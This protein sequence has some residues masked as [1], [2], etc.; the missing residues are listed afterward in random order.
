MDTPQHPFS[1]R[2][3]AQ[4]PSRP[5]FSPAQPSSTQPFGPTA[6]PL[7]FD[8]QLDLTK[9][10]SALRRRWQILL[11]SLLIACGYAFVQYSLTP[12][13]YQAT[14][15]VQIERKRLSLLALGQ[16]GWLEDWWNMEYYPT[17]Y[18][19]LRSRGM[20][21]KVVLHLGLHQNPSFAPQNK[22][23]TSGDEDGDSEHISSSTELAHLATSVMGRLEVNPIQE[24]QLVELTY[25]STDP[26][27]AAQIANTYAEVFIAWGNQDRSETVTKASDVLTERVESLRQEIEQGQIRL[28]AYI[29]G[30]DFALDPAGEALVEQLKTLRERHSAAYASRFEKEAFYRQISNLSRDTFVN[31]H[32]NPRTQALKSEL[33][34]LESQYSSKL[35]TY[36]PEWPEMVKLREAIE[37]KKEEVNRLSDEIYLEAR[38]QASAEY[39]L[40]KREEEALQTEINKLTTDARLQN[41][42][43][44]EY[45]NQLTYIDTRK[46]L[47]TDLVKRQS[48]IA[49]QLQSTQESNVR[50]VDRAI[51][52]GG[53]FRPSLKK[54]LGAAVVIGLA[55]GVGLIFLL[56]YLD[57]TIKTPDELESILGIPTLTVIP[58]LNDPGSARTGA[59]KYGYSYSY[60]YGSPTP[61]GE[62][63]SEERRIELLPHFNPRLAVSEAYR[64][65]RTALLLSSAD[66]LKVVALTSAEPGEGKTATTA[67]LAVVMAQLGRRVLIIDAD[68]RRPRMHKVF[69]VSNRHGLVHFLTN[70]SNLDS[71]F[72]PTEA[73]DLWICP[74]GPIPPNPSELLASDRMREFLHLVRAR[75]DFVLIDTPPTLPVADAVIL[76]PLADGIVVCARAGV[77]TRD[78]AKVC[79]ERLRYADLRIF[80]AVLNRYRS[81][82]HSYGKRYHYYGGYGEPGETGSEATSAA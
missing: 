69:N 46:E 78:D 9:Y 56:E 53:P 31:T 19:L 7:D 25:R 38:D 55:L 4:P 48:E 58:D 36:K 23:T 70:Q 2:E 81:S 35:S 49:T 6:S 43:A 30:S 3:E 75:F 65:L 42:S 40:A 44:L 21:E 13:E 54:S 63:K 73:P 28:N 67:N 47:L 12:K 72:L 61:P 24:T 76:G 14:A 57:R 10:F 37:K 66:E 39:Q 26:E 18:R 1:P 51:V 34:D 59:G 71:L 50:I 15:T 8:E 45:N 22:L 16:A 5:T 74:S 29:S 32:L 52:P 79:R 20:A 33:F 11:I 17:Q 64:S 82:S 60:G 77:L 68:L 41:S 27:Q 80:G 62:N